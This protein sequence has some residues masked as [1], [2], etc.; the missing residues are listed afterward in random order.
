MKKKKIPNK[1]KHKK[2]IADD[3]YEAQLEDAWHLITKRDKLGRKELIIKVRT[4]EAPG[5]KNE[6]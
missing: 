2:T 1:V 3:A 4:V 5:A 6:S